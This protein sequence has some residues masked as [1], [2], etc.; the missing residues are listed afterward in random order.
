MRADERIPKHARRYKR[1]CERVGIKSSAAD[2]MAHRSRESERWLRTAADPFRTRT[3][4]VST[5]EKTDKRA[6]RGASRERA[7]SERA[8]E[9]REREQEGKERV[10]SR[11]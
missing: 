11:P 2:A 1:K 10:G 4:G 6:E 7:E 8:R 5:R 3:R 9:R